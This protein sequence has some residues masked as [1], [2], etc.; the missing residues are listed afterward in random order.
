MLRQPSSVDLQNCNT[1]GNFISWHGIESVHFI[2]N[3]TPNVASVKGCLD[4]EQS[5]LQS[6][7]A[8]K[9]TPKIELENT[10]F[11]SPPSDFPNVKTHEAIAVIIPL[12]QKH[13]IS[14]PDRMIATQTFTW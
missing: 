6:T 1:N 5:N 12:F 13:S 4:Q 14:R 2:K 11:F 3:L 9:M 10:D 8:T 7:K